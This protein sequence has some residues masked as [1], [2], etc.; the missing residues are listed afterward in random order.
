M[1]INICKSNTDA[2]QQS[3]VTPTAAE[4]SKASLL[5]FSTPLE[6]TVNASFS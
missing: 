6:M 5:D 1:K 4:E 2:P 3:T